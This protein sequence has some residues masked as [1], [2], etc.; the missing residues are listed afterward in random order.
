MTKI[1]ELSQE[2]LAGLASTEN[3]SKVALCKV[4]SVNRVGNFQ[5]FTDKMLLHIKGFTLQFHTLLWLMFSLHCAWIK[6]CISM[7]LFVCLCLCVCVLYVSLYLYEC[8][9]VCLGRR[10]CQTRLVEPCTQSVN[11]GDCFVLVTSHCIWLWIGEFSNIIERSK[12]SVCSTVRNMRSKLIISC[13]LWWLTYKCEYVRREVS[14][15][16]M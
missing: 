16:Q 15:G 6:F 4:D 5:P 10:Y 8:M 7:C 1:P 12:V 2:A 3:F 9:F 13:V 14:C 11:S